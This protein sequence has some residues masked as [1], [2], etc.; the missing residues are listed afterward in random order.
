MDI[1]RRDALKLAGL[2]ALGTTGLGTLGAAPALAAADKWYGYNPDSSTPPPPLPV[3]AMPDNVG[4]WDEARAAGYDV[5]NGTFTS[6][7]NGDD[8]AGIIATGGFVI[9]HED[10]TLHDFR[11]GGRVES[12]VHPAAAPSV[13]C[14]D[15]GRTERGDFVMNG[16]KGFMHLTRVNIFGTTDGVGITSSIPKTSHVMRLQDIVV[17]SLRYARDSSQSNGYTH[18]DCVQNNYVNLHA[19]GCTF[20]AWS[21]EGAKEGCSRLGG[22][23]M[24]NLARDQKPANGYQTSAMLFG[25]NGSTGLVNTMERCTFRGHAAAYL[26]LQKTGSTYNVRNCSFAMD[27]N[28]KGRSIVANREN[29]GVWENNRDAKTGA[30]ILRP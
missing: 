22:P 4:A 26:F 23:N 7:R 24:G 30:V 29:L 6:R 21:F 1:T 2:V 19:I 9:K 11:S 15:I 27:E 20:L 12:L 18:N 5:Y 17:H 28:V 25:R 8:I 14:G 3:T 10:V 16:T 13:F